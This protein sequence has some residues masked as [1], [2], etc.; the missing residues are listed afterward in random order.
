M[1][2][3]AL[4]LLQHGASRLNVIASVAKCLL[5]SGLEFFRLCGVRFDGQRDLYPFASCFANSTSMKLTAG[6]RSETAQRSFSIVLSTP[7]EIRPPVAS[8]K[9]KY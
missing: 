4:K 8:R 5:V 7:A 2:S 9:V 3:A 6:L 1:L